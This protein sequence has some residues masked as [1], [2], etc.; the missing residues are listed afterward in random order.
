MTLQERIAEL[1]LAG[2]SVLVQG[3]KRLTDTQHVADLYVFLPAVDGVRKTEKVKIYIQSYETVDEAADF[4]DKKPSVLVV[5]DVTPIGT[6][7]DLLAATAVKWLKYEVSH[8]ADHAI[9]SGYVSLSEKESVMQSWI[10]KSDKGVLV[11]Y[12]Q[13]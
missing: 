7:E 9:V 4:I 1:E 11:A 6:D 13:K 12:Q 2:S 10:I 5:N 8:Q 3:I